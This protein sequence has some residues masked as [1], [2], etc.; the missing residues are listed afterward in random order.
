MGKRT[1]APAKLGHDDAAT[2]SRRNHWRT[3]FLAPSY[4]RWAKRLVSKQ[5]RRISLPT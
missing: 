2:A 3:A 4:R 1:H 5:A